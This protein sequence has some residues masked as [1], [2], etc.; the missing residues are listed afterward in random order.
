MTQSKLADVLPLTPLQEGMLFHALYDDEQAP[1]V[2]NVQLVF[3]LEGELDAAALRT[4]LDALLR[5]HTNLRAGFWHENVRRPV[6]VIPETAEV[7]W[8]LLDLTGL[9]E[10]ERLVKV[11]ELLDADHARRFEL[12]DPPLIRATLLKMAPR[13][14][15]FVLTHHHALLDGWSLPLLITE[16]LSLYEHHG[17]DRDLPPVTPYRNYLAWLAA[18]DQAAALEQ[19]RAV[20]DGVDE[21]TRLAAGSTDQRPGRA[22]QVHFALSEQA[23]TLVAEQA[24]RHGLT[25]NTLVQA[26][27]GVLIG[28]LTGREDVVFG[29]T[30]S[31]RPAELPGVESIIGLFINTVPLRLAHRATESLAQLCTRLQD[32]QSGLMD[33]QHISL[34]ELQSAV[35]VG[36][37]FDT[38]LVFENYPLD[39]ANLPSA[40]GLRIAGIDSQD[41]THYAVTL[42]V[43]P[44]PRMTFRL[45]YRPELIGRPDAEALAARLVRLL[46]SAAEDLSRPVGTL[47]VLDAEEHRLL[48][49]GVNDTAVPAAWSA[50]SVQDAFAGQA[51]RT[52][53][54]VALSFGEQQL[55]FA[56]LDRRANQLAHHLAGLGVGAESAVAVLQERSPDLVVATLAILKAGG[57]YVPL[58]S[59]QPIERMR[60]ALRETSAQVLLTDRAMRARFALDDAPHTVVVDDDDTAFRGPGHAPAVPAAPG[61]LAYIMYTS[62]S[63]GTP[64]AIG[65]THHDVLSLASDRCWRSGEGERVLMHSQYAFDISTYELWMP[66]LT[67]GRIV[68]A[69]P[70]DLDVHTYARLLADEGITCFMVTAGLFGLLAEERP[71][72]LAGVRE[73]WTGGDLVSAMALERVRERCPDTALMHLYGP[74]ETTLGATH[75]AVDPHHPVRPPLPIGRPLDNMRAYVL[76]SGLLPVPAGA[77]GELYL[78]GAGLA[79]GYLGRPDGTAERFVADPYGPA[80]SRMYRTGDLARR[81]ADGQLEFVGR[82][83][84]QVKIRG[85]RIE[86][87]EIEIALARFPSVGRATVMVR[88]D[89][90]GDKRLVAYVV[91][92][93]GAAI[94]TSALRDGLAAQLP[95]Y[96]V[97]SSFVV[98]DELPLTANGKVDRRALPAPADTTAGGRPPRDER[99]A[100][101]CAAYAEVLGLETVGID[102]D[103]FDLG[104]H[105]LLATR[106][107]SRLRALLGVELTIRTLFE[108]RTVARLNAQLKDSAGAERRPA[109]TPMPRPERI[110]LS[111]AQSR[112]WFLHRLEGPSPTYNIIR[113]L[114]LSGALDRGA[115]EA[116]LGDVVA[117]HDALRTVFA[118]TAGVAEQRVLGLSAAPQPLHYVRTDA[119]GFDAAFTAAARHSFDLTAETPLRATLFALGPDEHVLLLL[120]HHIAGDGW[121]MRPLGHDLA[122]AYA[123]RRAGHEPSW[124]PL[125]VQYVDYTLWQRE[126]LGSEDDPESTVSRQLDHWRTALAD[127][128]EQIALPTDRPRPSEATYLGDEVTVRMGSELHR[129]LSELAREHEASLFMVLQAG[130]AALLNRL[131]SG[132]DIPIGSPI[133]GRTDE[134]LDDLIGFFVNTLVLRT[135][136]S[137]DP[138]FRELLGRVQETDLAAYANQDVPFE[139]LVEVLNPERS[140]ARQPLFQVLLA[141]QNVPPAERGLEGLATEVVTA[142]AGVAKFDFSIALMENRTPQGEP[143]GITGVVEYNT[144]IFDART[145]ETIMVRL[146]RLLA[147]AVADPDRPVSD[148]DLLERA[149]HNRLTSGVV[150]GR[151]ELTTTTITEVFARRVAEAPD[152]TAVV[153]EDESLTYRELDSRANKVAHWL[154]D[155][156]VGPESLVALRMPRSTALIACVLGTWRAGAA[157]LPVDPAY[158]ADRIAYMLDDAH[159]AVVLDALP[160]GL[161]GLPDSAPERRADPANTAYTIYTSGSTGRPKGVLATHTGVLGLVT[162]QRE[163]LGVGAG[164][165][166]LQFASPSFDAAFWEICMALLSGATLVLAPAEKLLPGPALAA[167]AR[168]HDITH[169]TLPPSALAVLDDDA[170]PPHTTLVVAG[171]ACPPDLVARW[172]AGRRM[173]NAYGPT[174]ATVCATMS[175]P[176]AGAVTPSIG[177]AIVNAGA[178][179][180]DDRLRPVA[181]GVA[182]ELYLTGAGLARGYLNR[183]ALTADRFVPDPF[184]PAGSRMYRTGDT[185]RWRAD[186]DLEF[187][188]RADDQV[189]IHGFRIEPGEIEAQLAEHPEVGQVAVVPRPDHSGDNRLVAY[190]VRAQNGPASGLDEDGRRQVSEWRSAF[191]SQYSADSTSEF[192]S[193]FDGWNSTYDARPIPLDQMREWRA[194]AVDRILALNP[195]NVLEIGV[196][197]GLILSQVAPEVDAYWGTDLSTAAVATLGAGIADRPE[198]AAK[199]TLRAQPADVTEGLPSGFFDTVVLNS[200][201]QYFP[202]AAYLRDVLAKALDLLAPGGTV[203]LGDIRNLRLLRGLRTA[204]EL[205]RCGEHADPPLVRGLVEQS[206]LSEEELLVDPDYFVA[207]AADLDELAGADL[208]IKRAHHHNELSRHRYDVVLHKRPATEA[209]AAETVRLA[210]GDRI[211]GLDA[212][213]DHLT[214]HRPARLRVTGVPNGRLASE[215]AAMRVLDA[216]GTTGEALTALTTAPGAAGHLDPE[217]FRDLGERLGLHTALTWT[218]DG[219]EGELDVVFTDPA[220]RPAAPSDAY[221]PVYRTDRPLDAGR[222]LTNDPARTRDS[223]SVTATL[224]AHLQQRL[225]EYMVPSAFVLVDHFPTTPNGKLDRKALPEPDFAA[226]LTHRAPR[227]PREEILCALFAEVLGLPSVGIDDGFFQLGGHSLLATR[228]LS[229]IRTA[230]GADLE[231][232]HLFEAPTVAELARLV[233]HHAHSDRPALIAGRRPEILPLSFAQ[234]RLWFLAQLEGSS[235]VYNFP[236]ALRLRGRPDRAA[237]R[238]AVADVV[239]RH[240]SLRTVFPETDGLVRQHVLADAVPEFTTVRTTESELPGRLAEI[241]GYEFDLAAEPPLRTTLFTLDE[242]EHVLVLVLHHIAGD[243]WSLAPLAKDLATA[244]AARQDG[245]EPGWAPLPVQYADYALWQRGML[246]AEHDVTSL[247]GRQ[248][249]Y[250]KRALAGLPEEITPPA[251]R[252]R[253]AVPTHRGARVPLRVDAR[254]HARLATVARE[255]QATMFMVLHTALAALLTRL[256]AGE[257]IA[258]GTPVAGRTDEALDDLIGFFVNTLVLRADTSG[259]PEFS[260]LLERVREGDLA[261][262]AHQDVPFERLVEALNPERTPARQPLFQVM[263]ALQN[264]PGAALGLPG[265]EISGQEIPVD[266]ARF[267]LTL[268]LHETYGPDGDQGGIE[269]VVEYST[270]LFDRDTAERLADG[271]VRLLESVAADPGRRVGDIELLTPEQRAVILGEWGGAGRTVPGTPAATIPELFAGQVVRTPGATALTADGQHLTYEE[272]DARANRLAR[273]LIAKGVG[274]ERTVALLLPRSAEAVVALLAVLKAGGAYLPLDPDHPAQRLAFAVQDA[275]PVLALA[276]ASTASALPDGLDAV[277]LDA[278]GSGVEEYPAHGITDAERIAPLSVDNAAYVIYTSGST[279]RPKGVVVAHRNVGRLFSAAAAA[280]T[281]GPEDVW[282][283]FHSYAFD[284]SVW[285]LWGPL[286]HGGRL[287]VVPHAV[288]RSPEEF[289][290]LL[291]DERVTVLSQTPSAFNL[292]MEADR[293]NPDLGGRLALRHVVFGGEALEPRRLEDW[294]ARHADDAPVLVNMY[295]I[296]ETTVH[297]THQALDRTSTVPGVGGPIGRGLADL[298]VYLLDAG[299]RPVPVGVTAEMYVAGGGVT[300]GYLDRAALT[301]ERFVADPYGQP[302]ARMYRTGDLARWRADGTLE[303]LG[304]ADQQVKVRGHRIELG[305]IEA[306]LAQHPDVAQAAAATRQDK[307]GGQHL[308]GYAVPRPGARPDVVGL[309][310]FVAARLPAYMVPSAFLLVERLELTPNGKLDRKALPEPDFAAL[311]TS[312][313]PD[314][315]A[316]TVL[317]EVFAEVLGLTAVGVDDS[318]FELGGDSITS[319][320]LVSGARR[321]GLALSVRDIFEHKTIAALAAAV[322]AGASAQAERAVSLPGTGAV[323]ATPII[324]WLR[325]R[326][327]PIGRFGQSVVLRVPAGLERAHLVGALRAV[328]DHHDALRATLLR[329]DDGQWSLEVPE[330]GTADA[331]GLL[332]R[333]DASDAATDGWERLIDSGVRAAADRLDPDR[334]VMVQA[335][336]FDAGDDHGRLALVVHHLVVDAVTWRILLPDLAAAWEALSTGGT[337]RLDPVTTSFRHWADLLGRRAVTE[338]VEK[339]LPYWTEQ[340]SGTDPVLTDRPLDPAVDTESA[341]RHVAAELPPEHTAPL[342][343]TVPAAFHARAND[344]LVASFAVA[345]AEWRTGRTGVSTGEVLIDMEGHG[346]EEAGLDVDLVRTAGWFTSLYPVR[347]DVGQLGEDDVREGGAALGRAVMRVKEQLRA[348]PGNGLGFG[349]LRYLNPRSAAQLGALATPQVGFNYLGR[350]GTAP[351]G[352]GDA[353]WVISG[354]AGALGGS[355]DDRLP[356]AHALEVT[357]VIRDEAAGPCLAVSLTWADGTLAEDAAQALADGWLRVLG[358]LVEHTRHQEVG[359]HTPSDLTLGGLSQDD[360]DMFEDELDDWEDEV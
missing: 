266:V 177:T 156:G 286:L 262:Y 67:G 54:A 340:L 146:E 225:P 47:D 311:T 107:V 339:E 158:P 346:R 263:L 182:G 289:L 79:R 104:G 264:T 100:E 72:C 275:R 211:A 170:L 178:Y 278:P 51:A 5:R 59:G 11:A 89:R 96:M 183:P 326:G 288:S 300:R 279:G 172:S 140:L 192:G 191:E 358:A 119:D 321:A 65:I 86:P 239:H 171:E 313:G 108:T 8:H 139:R 287:V 64:K 319:I 30:V 132:T 138:T 332:V 204:A 18:Q 200:V 14:H 17:D 181:P 258:I 331:D 147:A 92:A 88:E 106:L 19:W 193:N 254:S 351:A 83:D 212:L 73:V 199:V 354:E 55:T 28:R 165:R 26:A 129:R 173:V 164:S 166:V 57:T 357:A 293:A 130:L 2:Y 217:D 349:L 120:L 157:Y 325:E 224:R 49:A 243:G 218:A 227:T 128:P 68:V 245:R 1:D 105:S 12:A 242:D 185:A 15:R 174:E 98:L 77:V 75:H 80:G 345:L 295:G 333:V 6:Q 154:I 111:S 246:G 45:N 113:G 9:P 249:A 210:W 207:L 74:T 352:D 124:A 131:G 187:L 39:R 32:Q 259:N 257:D 60:A 341:T 37:L 53:D 151:P 296:T 97:P 50:A 179:V 226:L 126:L 36:E 180:L 314:T 175:A 274:P 320:Q 38:V 305:E 133:A 82:A 117:R 101:L 284:F 208:Q 205:N 169:V 93:P 247:A 70:G 343:A 150:D 336:W 159:P 222:T 136:V 197:S 137:G 109:L 277:V 233:E 161:D 62:G 24:R 328:L 237:L 116:A 110:P 81:R 190:V 285:E 338:E 298:R 301:A 261:A 56:E 267:D 234:Q 230:L 347:V 283:L 202:N 344:V 303:Y 348:V 141:L 228:L 355:A 282:T 327:G 309:R 272:L 10:D 219:T 118:E 236:L 135:D 206:V 312:R 297:V 280:M 176:L 188:G 215:I 167:L 40:P 270:D 42:A 281:F 335:V 85:F 25:V 112:L 231:V 78:A 307:Q 252:P 43:I 114:R 144:D 201:V 209:P 160:A 123:A 103:F 184:G 152:A 203:F 221:T 13:L 115:L 153:Y 291:V 21:P 121:S 255:H 44:G 52:P 148:I 41:A 69:P 76:G 22:G 33:L 256:G 271:F 292:L 304:R 315:A 216:G 29:T 318:F 142:G 143:D 250:W 251:D 337:P 35:G 302:G 61:Q 329:A 240:E 265:L 31:G 248:I 322:T 223:G 220:Q 186:G 155:Q 87:G 127:L 214:G 34:A 299:L 7:P 189:K 198:L 334:G 23:T 196:G 163:R 308:T 330:P 90:P 94:T 194:A 3:D 102:D 310:D 235:S 253:P 316:E 27:W 290:Q 162:A 168:A 122:E 350:F 323:P 276:L 71:E 359:R 306:V 145:V 213:A 244:Y 229:R 195:R 342:L 360:I 20:L 232:R 95:D 317:C 268:H 260:A 48:T 356:V 4:A 273:L 149:E 63:T 66:L 58:H 324:H 91:A 46:E 84:D 16:L 99:E 134:G 269:G 241:V 238:A 294:Y 353:T 125:P